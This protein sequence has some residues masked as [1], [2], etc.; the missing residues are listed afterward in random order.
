M[1]GAT[2]PRVETPDSDD[3]KGN[4]ECGP[5]QTIVLPLQIFGAEATSDV[6][7]GISCG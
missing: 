3:A 2:T 4:T 6:A 5:D 7:T 1:S